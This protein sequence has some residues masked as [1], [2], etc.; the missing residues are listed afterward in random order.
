MSTTNTPLDP[1]EKPAEGAVAADL[2]DPRLIQARGPMGYLSALVQ[3]LKSGDIGSLPIIVGL[4]VIVIVFQSLNDTFL[5]AFNLVN[6]CLQ[7]A[8]LTIIALGITL[9]LLLGE[10]DL[11]IGSVSGVAA[12]IV[13]VA[14]ATNG[15]NPW[16]SVLMAVIA[17][18]VIGLIHGIVFTKIGVP[19]F[20]ITLAGLLGWLGV[21]LQILG[22]QGTVNMPPAGVLIDIGQQKFL[23]TWLT[24]TIGFALT[25]LYVVTALTGSARR[26]KAGLSGQ[27]I[28]VTAVVAAFL[29]VVTV[30]LAYKL[31]L[32]RGLPW[33]FVFAV[34]LVLIFDWI[35]RRTR[36]GRSILAVGGNIE[37]A[38]RA[39]IKVD[40][41]RISVFMLC[42]T[43][44]A[45]GGV[46]AAMRLGF[47]NQQS[48]AGDVLVN[49]IAAAVIGGTSLF[50]GRTRRYAPLLGA[51]VIGAI[52]N[53]LALMSLSSSVKYIIT[54]AV[55]LGAVVID[56]ASSRG[57]K[58]SGR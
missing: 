56:A 48:G 22:E 2:L 10:I 54:G 58:S 21:Q 37:A 29:V 44:A 50:G 52:A 19:S 26:R 6:L 36:Y 53:G 43:L 39:G 49:S 15:V 16:L 40:A 33:I 8:S 7:I 4:V 17:G 45:V 31:G 32:D 41:I 55:L 57:R 38:R 27:P 20:V 18:T 46:I 5:N 23:P 34:A 28:W 3:R 35:I 47:A 30:A 11:S 24:Y 12:A 25:A 42:S 14:N 9:V 13:A 1:A 51:V